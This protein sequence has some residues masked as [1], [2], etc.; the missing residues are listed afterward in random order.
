MFRVLLS[1]IFAFSFAS[2]SACQ[3][4]RTDGPGKQTNTA[5]ANAAA[6]ASNSA[7]EQK[8]TITSPDGVI[9]VGSF[10]P[11]GNPHAKGLLLLHQWQ[12]DRHS[13]DNLAKQ[14]HAKGFAVL[15]IDGRGF[16][17]STRAVDGTTVT[18]ERTDAAVKA[19]L[20]DVD[21][22]FEFLAKQPNVD[23][24][25]IGIVGA[26]YGSSLALI[27][28]ADHPRVGAVALLSPGM[29]YF[30]N[31]PTE[32]A[33]KKYGYRPMLFLAAEDDKESA[34]AVRKL[35]PMGQDKF[36][37]PRRIYP[38]GGHG[39]ALLTVGAGAELETFF[40]TVLDLAGTQLIKP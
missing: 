15:S 18:A 13:F 31:M 22:G 4:K 21:A 29:N 10:Y 40:N 16:G 3:S 20:G 23:A 38:T 11:A 1:L 33:V 14:L 19:M 24:W 5:P 27:Y 39:T 6:N 34:D 25:R 30:G 8:V 28:A 17:E 35:D 2:V 26:S 7:G 9:L 32:P 37:Y 12:S 36:L